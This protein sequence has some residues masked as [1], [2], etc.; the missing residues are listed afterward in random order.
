[1][2]TFFYMIFSSMLPRSLP[3]RGLVTSV[4][5]GTSDDN[6]FQPFARFHRFNQFNYFN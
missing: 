2:P 6:N 4:D 5:I 3:N 1:M